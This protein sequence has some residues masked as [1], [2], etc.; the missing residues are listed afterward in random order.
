MRRYRAHYDVIVMINN[1]VIIFLWSKSIHYRNVSWVSRYLKSPPLDCLLNSSGRNRWHQ[2]Q[3]FTGSL[4]GESTGGFP[5]Q[6]VSNAMSWR[7]H[8]P[9]LFAASQESSIYY[10]LTETLLSNYNTDV[11]PMTD[12]SQPLVVSIDMDLNKIVDMVSG[13]LDL[14]YNG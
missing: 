6:R 5:S 3:A 8:E 13:T 12:P 7:H 10:R 11:F 1:Y 9:N 2:R 14:H 4:W